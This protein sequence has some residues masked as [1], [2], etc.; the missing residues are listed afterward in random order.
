VFTSSESFSLSLDELGQCFLNEKGKRKMNL[1]VSQKQVA[2]EWYL[3][4]LYLFILPVEVTGTIFMDNGK[5]NDEDVGM[6]S[7]ETR[8]EHAGGLK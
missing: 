3:G 8:V 5:R 4:I 1:L 6:L 7:L 2:G